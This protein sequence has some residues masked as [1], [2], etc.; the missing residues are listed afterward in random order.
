MQPF[1]RNHGDR[2]RRDHSGETA[3][4]VGLDVRIGLASGSWMDEI[5][6]ALEHVVW[7]DKHVLVDW[8]IL[9]GDLQTVDLP[10]LEKLEVIWRAFATEH[11]HTMFVW[12]GGVNA[13]AAL[14]SP[15]EDVARK[16][17]ERA[18][19]LY[20]RVLAWLEV[21]EAGALHANANQPLFC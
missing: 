15:D 13:L 8:S 21:Y 9:E 7:S 17:L 19:A 10:L 1:R 5:N 16:A 20:P 2:L 18:K 4:E 11:S 6:G 14:L 12:S 3:A